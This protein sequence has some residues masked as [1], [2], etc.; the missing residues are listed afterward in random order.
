MHVNPITCSSILCRLQ[1][2]EDVSEKISLKLEKR[3]LDSPQKQNPSH[4]KKKAI[5]PKQSEAHETG[6]PLGMSD[7]VTDLVGY[8]PRLRNKKKQ[9]VECDYCGKCFASVQIMKRHQR[10]HNRS[11]AEVLKCTYCPKSF[12]NPTVL[13]HHLTIHSGKKPFQCE[14]CH[15]TFGRKCNLGRH[16]TIHT[17]EKPFQCDFCHKHFAQKATLTRHLRIH[18][19]EKPFHCEF[20]HKTFGRNSHL[21]RH[22]RIHTGEKPFQCEFCSKRFTRYSHLQSHHRFHTGEKPFQC[23][24]CPKRFTQPRNLKSHQTVHTGK[25][26]FQCKLCHKHFGFKSSFFRHLKTKS[27]AKS[28]AK[29]S[30]SGDSCKPEDINC[31]YC[32]KW[33]PTDVA[34][35]SHVESSHTSLTKNMCEWC[36]RTF[37]KEYLLMHYRIHQQIPHKCEVCGKIFNTSSYLKKHIRRCHKH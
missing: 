7:K 6:Q 1:H 27:H 15:K 21:R 31:R 22:L 32:L 16:L 33:F 5:S 4:H 11:R 24:F 12:G 19:K 37:R 3:K 28:V 29:R 35:R 10:T 25:K 36:G 18:T 9:R 26:P 14:F 2:Q 34:L 20:C 8:E 30:E 17:G 23:E 13:R